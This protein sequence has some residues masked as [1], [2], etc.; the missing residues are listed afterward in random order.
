MAY[1]EI[2]SGAGLARHPEIVRTTLEQLA[3]TEDPTARGPSARS[4]WWRFDFEYQQSEPTQALCAPASCPSVPSGPYR[5]ERYMQFRNPARI[6]PYIEDKDY[7][8][9]LLV[10][11]VIVIRLLFGELPLALEYVDDPEA[12]GDDGLELHIS[13]LV[14]AD[15]ALSVLD[16]LDEEWWLDA[17]PLARGRLSI[18]AE[19]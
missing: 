1:R 4:L 7:L 11:A 10:Q 19:F 8:G 16:R 15:E 6:G 2:P 9:E 5:L 14:S 12:E 18:T 13:G 17:L 3:S